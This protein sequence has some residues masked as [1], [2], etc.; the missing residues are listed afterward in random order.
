MLNKVFSGMLLLALMF[1][2][3]VTFGQKVPRGK[4]WQMPQLS[5]QLNLS[6]EQNN[7]LDELYLNNRRNLID[8]KST[9]ERERLELENI[10]DQQALDEAAAVQQF[11]KLEAARANLAAERFR[12]FLQVRKTIGYERFQSLKTHFRKFRRQRK[13]HGYQDEG[14]TGRKGRPDKRGNDSRGM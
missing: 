12:Y 14:E 10:I 6:E 7:Q 5:E 2:P 3:A 1:S 13:R 11:K 9:V 4:W 8:L